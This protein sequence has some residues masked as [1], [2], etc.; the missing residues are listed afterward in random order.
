VSTSC[1]P[2]CCWPPSSPTRRSG[3]C[4]GYATWRQPKG[5]T[6]SLIEIRT[7][8]AL[9]RQAAGDQI[10][11]LAALAEALALAAPEGY[12]RTFADEGAPM[13]RLLG[14]LTA[15]HHTGQVALPAAVAPPYLDRLAQVFQPGGARPGPRATQG[16]A[17]AAGLAQALSDRELEVLA[18]L[19]AGK[20][21]QQIADELVVVLAT[22]KK[23]VGHILG[24]LAAANRTQAVAR[25]RALGLLR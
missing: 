20:S 10:A 8:Q 22:V 25:A 9:A 19:S 17:T 18:L 11:A 15:A 7:L 2:G 12:V 16:T 21:N 6:G 14:K 4:S 1:W 5:R 13:T 23:H 3:C 24:K